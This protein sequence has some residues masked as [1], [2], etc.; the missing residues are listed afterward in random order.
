[1]LSNLPDHKPVD[2][3]ETLPR[4]GLAASLSNRHTWIDA[5][6]GRAIAEYRRSLTKSRHM[7]P[8]GYLNTT[9]S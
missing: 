9:L 4:F 8:T 2:L 1:M 3:T 7:F 6:R 5:P